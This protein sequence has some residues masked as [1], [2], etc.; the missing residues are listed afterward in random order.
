MYI[1]QGKALIEIEGSDGQLISSVAEPGHCL[2]I[3]PLTKHRVAALIK[4]ALALH[5]RTL[6]PQPYVQ[7]PIENLSDP[8]SP[9]YLQQEA[10]PWLHLHDHPRRAGVS[11]FGFG[12][13]NCHC[14]LEEYRDQL[15][16]A[17]P[18]GEEWPAELV[19]LAAADRASLA[20]EVTQLHDSLAAAAA[21]SLKDIAYSC[22]LRAQSRSGPFS[23]S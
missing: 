10:K 23:S 7:T 3:P 5:Y 12:G 16:R 20:D 22:A 15:H 8:Q 1:Y 17:A 2:R 11:A 19:L 6:P 14:V 4:T 18:G 9:V 13:T 21:P